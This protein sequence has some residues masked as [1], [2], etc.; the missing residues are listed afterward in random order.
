[1][2]IDISRIFKSAHQGRND[3]VDFYRSNAIEQIKT[4]LLHKN[5]HIE[6]TILL[7]IVS[8]ETYCSYNGTKCVTA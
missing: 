4:C 3:V 8:H 5:R 7:N 6:K 1:M 2:F